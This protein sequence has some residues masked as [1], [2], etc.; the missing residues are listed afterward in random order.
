MGWVVTRE[1][2][3]MNWVFG[4][5]FV[6]LQRALAST[7]RPT[8]AADRVMGAE[9][10]KDP[11]QMRHIRPRKPI[12]EGTAADSE[13]RIRK[14]WIREYF[15]ALTPHRQTRGGSEDVAPYS[16]RG[17]ANS[18]LA[19]NTFESRPSWTACLSRLRCSRDC[20]RSNPFLTP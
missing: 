15:N 5:P 4:S 14:A 8:A 11:S 6:E 12:E 19:H 20:Q 13:Y 1:R 16:G 9:C 7:T 18:S 3:G 2:G 17:A 10:P